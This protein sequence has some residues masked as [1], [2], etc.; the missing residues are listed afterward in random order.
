MAH[1]SWLSV[2]V[3]NIV[4]WK[5]AL[6]LMKLSSVHVVISRTLFTDLLPAHTSSTALAV[7]SAC[8]LV[9]NVI[10]KA[11]GNVLP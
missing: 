4:K 1:Q 10:L 3:F 11:L 5:L 9:R 6:E 2:Q 7:R 8:V